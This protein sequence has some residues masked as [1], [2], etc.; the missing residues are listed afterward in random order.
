[1]DEW[2]TVGIECSKR[3]AMCT[4]WFH[5]KRCRLTLTRNCTSLS[6]QHSQVARPRKGE[7]ERL[8]II[9]HCAVEWPWSNLLRIKM[10]NV[11]ADHFTQNILFPR[12]CRILCL[13]LWLLWLRRWLLRLLQRHHIRFHCE[14]LFRALICHLS[15]E[16]N[17]SPKYSV[18]FSSLSDAFRGN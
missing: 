6:I 15:V 8:S 18:Q 7:R 13:L 1:M 10:V 4:N 3:C 16:L 5:D 11:F 14:F 17:L 12:K 9:R 2:I